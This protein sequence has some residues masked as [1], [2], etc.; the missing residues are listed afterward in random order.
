MKIKVSKSDLEVALQVA[1]IAISGSGSDL[2]T[3]YL[4]RIREQRIEVLTYN[5][6]R[7]CGKAFLVCEIEE[8]EEGD[9]MTIEGWRLSDWLS[10]VKDAALTLEHV[11]GEVTAK[12][13]RSTIH[14]K[15]LD[16]A[17]FPF[18]DKTLGAAELAAQVPADRLKAALGYVKYFI[19][20]TETDK[21]EISQTEVLDGILWAT[22]KRAVTKVALYSTEAAEDGTE[23]KT[24]L[25]AD[26]HL[27]I[28]GQDIPSVMKFL[29]LKGTDNA[30]ILEH[31]RTGF[32]RRDD[33]ALIET[34]R[35][36]KAF[37]VL[38]LP[39]DDDPDQT[40]WV[41]RTDDLRDGFSI[42]G[43][44]AEKDDTK[45]QFKYDSEREQVMLSVKSASGKEDSFPLDLVESEGSEH[46]PENGFV[47]D[48]PYLNHI[49]THFGGD[50][51]SFGLSQR[52]TGGYVRFRHDVGADTFLTVVVWRV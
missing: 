30:E 46:L 44:S 31:K 24:L 22:D 48:Y 19:A 20:D 47:V 14:I 8:G 42:L 5:G 16:P 41:I 52:G 39:A 43:A 3:H 29:G 11:Q 15:S 34:S 25:L 23:T 45:V 37:P 28:Q 49:M 35:P 12:S 50:T 18:F 17:K 1:S 2:S 40:T 6:Q 26:A 10:G 51:L 27:R 21:P 32:L 33:G 36:L 13:P 4:F 9:A 38:G 7:I